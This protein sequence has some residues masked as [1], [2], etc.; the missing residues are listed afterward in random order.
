MIFL[1]IFSYLVAVINMSG[2]RL[3]LLP[4]SGNER[5]IKMAAGMV[6]FKGIGHG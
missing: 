6:K 4:P 1:M 3:P 5:K 2:V